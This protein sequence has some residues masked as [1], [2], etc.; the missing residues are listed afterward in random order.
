MRFFRSAAILPLDTAQSKAPLAQS[1]CP[2]SL[3][4]STEPRCVLCNLP[5]AT[6]THSGI[7]ALA[8]PPMSGSRNICLAQHAPTTVRCM[9]TK[10]EVRLWLLG[11]GVAVLVQGALTT[12]P[13]PQ[14]GSRAF[15]AA[16]SLVLI[17]LVY[18]RS[19]V[20]RLIFAVLAAVGF[21]LFAVA[22]LGKP[23]PAST[24]LALVYAVQVTTMLVGPVRAWTLSGHADHVASPAN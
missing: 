4:R 13:D 5:A 17:W 15:W 9:L 19:N 11:A 8:D 16:L 7:N 6:R 2:R 18:R 20:A 10:R 23:T 12:Y 14:V 3:K 22:S 24:S 1:R 21:A